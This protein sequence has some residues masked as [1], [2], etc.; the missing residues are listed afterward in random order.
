MTFL[1]SVR[2]SWTALRDFSPLRRERQWSF[3][4]SDPPFFIPASFD[5]LL[6]SRRSDGFD[7]RG[8]M[9]RAPIPRFAGQGAQKLRSEAR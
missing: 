7:C 3:E 2:G 5:D 4:F 8:A 1:K 6:S 9:F